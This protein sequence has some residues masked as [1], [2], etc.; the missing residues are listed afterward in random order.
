MSIGWA[1][2]GCVLLNCLL[3]LVRYV[4][5]ALGSYQ[6]RP[7]SERRL[8]PSECRSR[9]L[10]WDRPRWVD[11]CAGDWFD[12]LRPKAVEAK[13]MQRVINE[14]TIWPPN[15]AGRRRRRITRIERL[16][17][18]LQRALPSPDPCDWGALADAASK[19]IATQPPK[20]GWKR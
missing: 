1:L 19:E 3:V 17:R 5:A 11:G 12:A 8:A 20:W 16:L 2:V 15:S 6:R 7:L 10:A 13:V 4:P 14:A 18:L 9:G